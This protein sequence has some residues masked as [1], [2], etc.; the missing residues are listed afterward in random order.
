MVKKPI[1]SCTFDHYLLALATLVRAIQSCLKNICSPTFTN[2]GRSMNSIKTSKPRLRFSANYTPSIRIFLNKL[3]EKLRLIYTA[4]RRQQR[5]NDRWPKQT[6]PKG[7]NNCAVNYL[8]YKLNGVLAL[9]HKALKL[10]RLLPNRFVDYH[11][12]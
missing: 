2:E 11:V 4:R 3:H 8:L 5:G 6:S 12:S 1:F 9:Q 7:K 10:T